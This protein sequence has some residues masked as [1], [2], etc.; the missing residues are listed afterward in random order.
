MAKSPGKGV[1]PAV[2]VLLKPVKASDACTSVSMVF[3]LPHNAALPHGVLMPSATCPQGRLLFGKDLVHSFKSVFI[4]MQGSLISKY[5]HP[6]P[7]LLL[8]TFS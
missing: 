6:R 7:C 5:L 8:V 2:P 3:A 4:K 1:D